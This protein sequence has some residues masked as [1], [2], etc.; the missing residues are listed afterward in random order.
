MKTKL[1]LFC[2]ILLIMFAFVYRTMKTAKLPQA[3]AGFSVSVFADKLDQPGFIIF[4]QKNRAIVS[5][6]A[7]GKVIL[8]PD[9]V[10]LEHLRMPSGLALYQNYLYIAERH[11]VSRWKYDVERGKLID[12]AGT[13]IANL[14]ASNLHPLHAMLFG[15]NYR[16]APL[17]SGS[18]AKE[19]LNPNKLY[20]AAGSSCDVCVEDTWKRA[21][22]LESD[23]DGNFTAEYAGGLRDPTGLAI[24]PTT[25][26]LWATEQG[27]DGLPDE[28]NILQAPP[29]TQKFGARRYGWPFCYGKQI[30][31]ASFHPAKI[32]R[33]DIP[34]DCAETEPATMEFPAD[35]DP[36]GLVFWNEALIVALKDSVTRDGKPLLTDVH[37][38]SLAVTP[39]GALLVV[40][41]R[42]G[43]VY[44]I[45]SRP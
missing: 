24:H 44:Q 9:T 2:T 27:T 36:A 15:P 14:V 43:K 45:T 33:I 12:T 5:E 22:V 41:S 39:D 19:T 31:D 7:S 37:P 10:L 6:P 16:Q 18:H 30:R 25:H 40:D 11:Q 38:T 23:P 35:V 42:A 1:I 13:N 32:D 8:L 4:D 28:I 3:V 21:A 17:I 34:Q 26:E 29:P 20:I